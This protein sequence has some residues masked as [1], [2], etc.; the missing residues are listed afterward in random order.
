MGLAVM[1][2]AGL[3]V[4]YDQPPDILVDRSGKLMAIRAAD[5]TLLLSQNR[6]QKS[7]RESWTKQAGQG[8]KS[9]LWSSSEDG[10]LQCGR[11]GCRG[12]IRGRKLALLR[13]PDSP[14]QDCNGLDLLVVAGARPPACDQ[15]LLVV[16]AFDLER[17]G[18]HAIWVDAEKIRVETVADWQGQRP[19]SLNSGASVRSVAPEP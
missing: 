11:L 2:V 13:Y 10:S 7:L 19:W 15:A 9:P 18:T 14:I 5:G 6:S 12:Q 17:K 8:T 1:G 16:D 3:L 4:Y